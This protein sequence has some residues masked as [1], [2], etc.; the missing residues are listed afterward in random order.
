MCHSSVVVD[1]VFFIV[2]VFCCLSCLA[3]NRK[4]LP[5]SRPVI[6]AGNVDPA[7]TPVSLV[8]SSKR[9]LSGTAEFV[10]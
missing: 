9:K 8:P 10:R 4:V 2:V 5:M 7:A 1:N 3:D 6:A